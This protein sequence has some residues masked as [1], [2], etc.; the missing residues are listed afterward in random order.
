MGSKDE[1]VSLPM[2]VGGAFFLILALLHPLVLSIMSA[3]C[4]VIPFLVTC[5]GSDFAIL[6]VPILSSA[7]WLLAIGVLLIIGGLASSL[8]PLAQLGMALILLAKALDFL[9]IISLGAWGL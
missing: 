6:G 3:F 1:G 4:S 8:R 5:S 9:G 7:M 2:I